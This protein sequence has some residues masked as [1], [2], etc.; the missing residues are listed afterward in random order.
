MQDNVH[1]G[2]ARQTDDQT[3]DELENSRRIDIFLPSFWFMRRIVQDVL[4][5]VFAH[6]ANDNSPAISI[7]SVIRG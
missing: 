1:Q 5:F 4:R 7:N 3:D 2:Q 6:S